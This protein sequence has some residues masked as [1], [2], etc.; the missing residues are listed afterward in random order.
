MYDVCV[1]MQDIRIWHIAIAFYS[2]WILFRIY[3]VYDDDDDV[4]DDDALEKMMPFGMSVWM[5]CVCVCTYFHTSKCT[6]KSYSSSERSN[7][8]E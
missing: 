6:K 3:H 2:D 4:D 5:L 8:I 1:C 7:P